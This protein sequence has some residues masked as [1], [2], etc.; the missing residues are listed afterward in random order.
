RLLAL[1]HDLFSICGG[2]ERTMSKEPEKP[3][4]EGIQAIN[5][6]LHP[7][8]SQQ[9]QQRNTVFS[10]SSTAPASS[11]SAFSFTSQN[12]QPF[13]ATQHP[14]M[15]P[16]PP[17]IPSQTYPNYPTTQ[18]PLPVPPPPPIPGY[19][20]HGYAPTPPPAIPAP[21]PVPG[22]QASSSGPVYSSQPPMVPCFNPIQTPIPPPPVAPAT[23]F[24]YAQK[25]QPF[26]QLEEVVAIETSSHAWNDPPPLT[27][28]RPTPPAAPVFE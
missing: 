18:Q 19:Q 26:H 22:Y 16:R 2:E 14:G 27:A 24:Q 17:M 9:Q 6:A 20:Q 4:N 3:R 13:P 7:L 11:P 12:R 15:P 8:R 25:A 1:R 28:R 10:P 21:P 5:N 23:I